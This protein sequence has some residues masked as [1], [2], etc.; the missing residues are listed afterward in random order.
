MAVLGK[1]RLVIGLR[2]HSLIFAARQGVPIVSI[3]Y[4]PKIR[5]FM[6][7]AEVGGYLC[8]PVD[9][10]ESLIEK[11]EAAMAESDSITSRLRKSCREM[12]LRIEAE[13]RRVA[14]VLG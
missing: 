7:L 8:N 3:D 5:G 13:A 14:E 9:P 4:D 10:V 2:L 11:A 6:E 1:M 12:R